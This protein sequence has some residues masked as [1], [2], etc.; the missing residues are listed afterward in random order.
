[1]VTVRTATPED[2][3]AVRDVAEAAWWAAYGGF[4]DPATVRRAVASWYDPDV[5]ARACEAG[6]D[7]R[8]VVAEVQGEDG[9]DGPRIAGFASGER[10][11]A[12]TVEV[13][14]LYV[15]PDRWGE[16]VGSALLDDLTAW[17]RERGADYLLCSVFAENVVGLQ[18]F[19]ER[20]FERLDAGETEVF[21]TLHREVELEAEL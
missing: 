7:L 16:G 3:E 1:M 19:E 15:H 13:H 9:A 10:T 14:S 20:G 18:F 11:W 12:D 6:E 2:A 8:V 4:L 5:L 21:G 17:A